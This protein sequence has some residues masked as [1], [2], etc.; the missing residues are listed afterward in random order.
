MLSRLPLRTL[1]TI[2]YV[3]LLLLLA[4]V[5]GALSYHAGKQAIDNLSGQLLTETVH[6]IAQ[7]VDR[8]VAGSAA[9]LEA[10][11]PQ[12]M[13]A[14][15]AIADDVAPM[16]TRF[17]LATSVHRDPNNYAYYGNRQG[18][19]FG[20]WRFSETEAELRL[21][22]ASSGPRSIYRFT[23]I[24]GA[25]GAPV[26][27]ER[28]FDPR[29]RPWFVAAQTS[30]KPVWTSIYIDFRTNELVATRTRRVNN[31]AGEFEGVVATDLSLQQVNTFLQKL[32]V[33]A[34]G[35]AMV[36]EADGNLIGVS[37]GPHLR[38]DGGTVTNARLNAAASSDALVVATYRAIHPLVAAAQDTRPRTASFEDEHGRVVQVGY[39]R[40]RDDAGLDWPIMVAVPRHDFLHQIERNNAWTAALATLAALLVV[41][42]GMLVLEVV[43]RELRRMAQSARLM[44]EGQ[45][46]PLINTDRRDEL[47]DLARTFDEMQTRLLTDQL[48]GLSNR[49]ALLRRMEERLLQRRRRSDTR[50]FV[51]FFVDIDRFKQINDQFG[52]DVGDEVLRTFG[53]RLRQ[54]I[55]GS[56]LV[57]RWAGDEFVLLLESVENRRDAETV[58]RHLDQELRK[59][60][61]PSSAGT[62]EAPLEASAAIGVAIYP[63]DG[64]DVETLLKRADEDMYRR[65]QSAR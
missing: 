4:S 57:A 62:P 28:L 39:A 55:R 2:P 15:S 51:V 56:D 64:N 30:P 7:S 22:T 31:L 45:P 47:G 65:K 6:R 13:A 42:T 46:G 38:A 61:M 63:E 54:G 19:F 20:L 48:T 59:P 43:T 29:E 16:R 11:F 60:L 35:I 41:I 49:E 24:D 12:G 52:H 18:Q 27:E 8:H 10:A 53:A 44:G 5:V 9:V 14:P 50:P 17:W 21:R 23:G 36:V 34:N 25:L 37:R 3:V 32:A 58:R 1:L 40:L 33:S 26:A